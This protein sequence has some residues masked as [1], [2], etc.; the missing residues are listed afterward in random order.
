[1]PDNP[2]TKKS[3]GQHWLTDSQIL[4]SIADCGDLSKNDTVL[5][6][7]PGLGTLTS[8]LV[9]SAKNVVAVE[10]D[11]ELA[12]DLPRRVPVD[13]LVVV[14][15]DILQFDFGTLP[16]NYKIVANIPYYLTSHLIRILS[17]SSNPPSTAI[18]LIQKEL[19]ERINATA[20][21]MSLLSVTAQYYWH[22]QLGRVV[23]ATYFTPQP[24][25]DSQ[26]LTLAR[27]TDPLF[28]EVN[29]K[30]YFAIVKAGF[31]QRRKTLLNSLSAGLQLEKA[32]VNSACEITGIAASRR[33]QS[34]SLLEWY[35]L[36]KALEAHLR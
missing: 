27:H 14:N 4:K 35:D 18:L 17:E 23:P 34:L 33:A 28:K 20:G 6:I 7:G 2:I 11:R 15:K 8:F 13:N 3:L 36:T 21:E 25:V 19:A 26:I 12:K 22:T 9:K 29:T 10:F 5:E 24:K 16:P 32:V 30:R 1:M 31:S